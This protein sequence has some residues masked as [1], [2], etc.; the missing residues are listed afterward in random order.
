ML[1]A[2]WVDFL[3]AKSVSVIGDLTIVIGLGVSRSS[4]NHAWMSC[5]GTEVV[6]NGHIH[7]GKQRF[8]C[9]R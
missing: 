1:D 8:K 3:D 5:H 6:K 2:F 9:R 4:T 7:I